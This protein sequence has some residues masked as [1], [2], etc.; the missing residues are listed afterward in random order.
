M[1]KLELIYSVDIN[2]ITFTIQIR[3]LPIF[4]YTYYFLYLKPFCLYLKFGLVIHKTH[5]RDLFA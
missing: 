2:Y 3:S 4:K 1:Y 5:R